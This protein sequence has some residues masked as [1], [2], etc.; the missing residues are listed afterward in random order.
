MKI[1]IVG[2]GLTGCVAGRLLTNAGHSVTIYDTR[3]H[4]AGNCYDKTDNGILRHVYGPHI[5][6]T[7]DK[8]IFDFFS[9]FTDWVDFKLQPIGNTVLG[10]IPLPYHNSGCIKAI[11]R[12]FS[13]SEIT[14]YIF[15]DYSEKQWGVTFDKIPSTITNR[16]P[17]TVNSSNPTWF[18]G[19]SFQCIPKYGYSKMFESMIS[20]ISLNLGSKKNDWKKNRCDLV[21][22]TGPI[23][24]FFSYQFGKLGY[25]TL[26]FQNIFTKNRMNYFIQNECNS[27]NSFTR[28]YD[29]SYLNSKKSE[30]TWITKE[31]SRACSQN[32]IPF[33][34]I[35][36]GENQDIY[37]SYK[38]LAECEKD[39]IFIG[40]L[41]TYKYLDMWMAARQVFLKL[42]G[43]LI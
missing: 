43:T 26:D 9:N 13:Q 25:R 28:M 31:F 29:H 27:H 10:K 16:I 22:Y 35:P 30:Y 15:K 36:W 34:P 39:V 14:K 11:G 1:S 18:E 19:Q 40:R 24:E 42:K 3:E 32:D 41:A 8:F 33:Y 37:K 6:H 17:K 20:G 21:I 2:A 7:D 23:D 4:I 12:A 38:K 5:F